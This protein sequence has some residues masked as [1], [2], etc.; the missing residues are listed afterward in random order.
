M[1]V[2]EVEA[3]LVVGIILVG[4]GLRVILLRALSVLLVGLRVRKF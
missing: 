4:L 2:I 1:V 3:I